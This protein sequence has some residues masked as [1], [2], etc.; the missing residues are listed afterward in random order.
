M[1][2]PLQPVTTTLEKG[3]PFFN[4]QKIEDLEEELVSALYMPSDHWRRKSSHT[5]PRC[6]TKLADSVIH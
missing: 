2:L 4:Y 3:R 5:N 6:G 1:A